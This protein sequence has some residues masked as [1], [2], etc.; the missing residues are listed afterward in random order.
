MTELQEAYDI[1][2]SDL[3]ERFNELVDML[4]ENDN[5]ADEQRRNKTFE[6]CEFL[7][8]ICENI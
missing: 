8:K 7:T 4:K 6:V 2:I 3:Q 5:E 1:V